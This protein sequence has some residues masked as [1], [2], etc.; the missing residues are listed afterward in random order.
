MWEKHILNIPKFPQ[1]QTK[2]LDS[3]AKKKKNMV[4]Y[5]KKMMA[6]YHLKPQV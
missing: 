4:V 3:K 1:K 6:G 5:I 2:Q